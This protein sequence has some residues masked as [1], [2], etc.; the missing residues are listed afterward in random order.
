MLINI[1]K[2]LAL[3]FSSAYSAGHLVTSIVIVDSW[4]Q[5][6]PAAS[7]AWF[8][9]Y[10]VKLGAV[11]APFGFLAVAFTLVAFILVV[12][13]GDTSPQKVKWLLALVFTVASMAL[14]PIYFFEANALFFDRTI[15]LSQV[16]D[17]VER[18]GFWNWIRTGLS[19]AATAAILVGMTR[20]S[21]EAHI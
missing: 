12:K 7:I 10:G 20:T 17:E 4:S 1:S 6:E 16:A 13:K 21:A 18:W 5:M 19:L 2:L 11:M 3:T 9:V 8:G 14:L 15:E